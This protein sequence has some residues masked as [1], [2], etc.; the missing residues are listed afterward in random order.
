MLKMRY[1]Q[2]LM[3]IVKKI[4]N[5]YKLDKVNK[6]MSQIDQKQL[7]FAKQF[8]TFEDDKSNSPVPVITYIKQQ[9]RHQLILHILLSNSN[10]IGSYSS[11]KF[12]RLITIYI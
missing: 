4:I 6:E 11:Q 7:K 9:M 2:A 12:T 8:L 10:R 3:E 5:L 1:F